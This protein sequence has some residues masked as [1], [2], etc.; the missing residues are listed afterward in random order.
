MISMWYAI[1]TKTG[2]ER[3]LCLWI[4]KYV[5]EAL[6]DAC[7]V[8]LVEQNKKINGEWRNIS[9]PLFPGYI[10]VSASEDGI[11]DFAEYLKLYKK[12]AVVLNTDG[13]FT[14][15][16]EEELYLIEKAFF[17]NGILGTSI[18]TLEGDR[19]NIISGPLKGFEGSIIW[20][21]RHKRAATIEIKMFGRVSRV[22]IGLEIISKA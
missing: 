9:K 17:N 2:S 4:D 11:N 13:V 14:P 1:W 19:I 6:Y 22:N 21:N 8:P 16:N 15:I 7:F 20:I 18:G 10:F 5:P 12:F 3:S